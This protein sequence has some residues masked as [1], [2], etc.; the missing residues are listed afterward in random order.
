MKWLSQLSNKDIKGSRVWGMTKL[1]RTRER[2]RCERAKFLSA[3]VMLKDTHALFWRTLQPQIGNVT[4]QWI[5]LL[6]HVCG[7]P[8]QGLDVS[9]KALLPHIIFHSNLCAPPAEGSHFYC[10]LSCSLVVSSFPTSFFDSLLLT[11][12]NRLLHD[13]CDNTNC[14]H[15]AG[16]WEIDVGWPWH[17]SDGLV[18]L[19]VLSDVVT[20]PRAPANNAFFKGALEVLW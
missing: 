12:R 10:K 9:L 5:Y 11:S 15:L 14:C 13:W 3:A 4:C 20:F 2:G 17:R 7:A 19:H 18:F 8:R 16:F 6:M 1:V